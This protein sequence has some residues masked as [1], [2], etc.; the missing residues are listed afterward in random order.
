M[1]AMITFYKSYIE[2]EILTGIFHY[3]TESIENNDNS[4]EEWEYE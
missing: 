3:I 4:E 2:K 1:S